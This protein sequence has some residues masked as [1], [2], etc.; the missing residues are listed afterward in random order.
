MPKFESS[1]QETSLPNARVL[2]NV[3]GA[4]FGQGG[5]AVVQQVVGAAA[6]GIQF[7]QQKKEEADRTAATEAINVL[8]SK[9]DTRLYDTKTGLMHR[10][11]KDAFGAPNEFSQG[12]DSD[13][14]EITKGL[15]N[16]RQ[17]ELVKLQAEELRISSSKALNRHLGL[18]S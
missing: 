15:A 14:E 8:Q 9:N 2:E 10:Q 18:R 4:A 7:A 12:F 5:S 16:D 3:D 6:Q 13:I 17:R 1:V 11:G